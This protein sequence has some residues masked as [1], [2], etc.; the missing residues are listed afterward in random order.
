MVRVYS[1]LSTTLTRQL[2]LNAGLTL[3]E[4]AI[5]SNGRKVFWPCILFFFLVSSNAS[6]FVTELW[7]QTS[8]NSTLN[9]HKIQF[10]AFYEI[11]F[12][13]QVNQPF[14]R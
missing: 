2:R 5:R 1:I 10:A 4:K 9:R 12:L 6:I 8:T 14:L 3:L 13:V 11:P 7:I